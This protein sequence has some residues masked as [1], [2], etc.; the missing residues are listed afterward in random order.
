M[1]WICTFSMVSI[2][3][4]QDN[5]AGNRYEGINQYFI[6]FLQTWTDAIGDIH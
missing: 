1:M 5:S 3:L 4:G 6:L 2:V